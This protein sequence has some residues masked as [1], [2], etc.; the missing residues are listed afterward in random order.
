MEHRK[1][2]KLKGY[3]L[4]ITCLQSFQDKPNERRKTFPYDVLSEFSKNWGMASNHRMKVKSEVLNAWGSHWGGWA[5]L[6]KHIL[7]LSEWFSNIKELDKHFGLLNYSDE[8]FIR[9]PQI[10]TIFTMLR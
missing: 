7:E 9:K 4:L 8:Y 1:P 2:C 6:D 5:F 10:I 3:Y